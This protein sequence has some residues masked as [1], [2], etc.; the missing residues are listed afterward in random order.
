MKIL[1]VD[2]EPMI[3]AIQSR[4]LKNW[5]YEVDVASDGQTAWEMMSNPAINFVISD[6]M[7]PGISGIDLC[8]KIR[9]AKLDR[10]VYLLLCTAKD[11]R[12]DIVA[13]LDA[14]ADDFLVK[15]IAPSELRVRVRSG[16]RVLNLERKLEDRNLE[17]QAVNEQLEEANLLLEEKNSRLKED[18]DAAAAIQ[19]SLLP[20]PSPSAPGIRAEWLFLPCHYVAGD[21]FNLCSIDDCRT[22]FYILDVSGHGVPAAMLSVQLSVLL[23]PKTGESLLKRW[24]TKTARREARPPQEVI[25]ALNK[26]FQSKEDRYFTMIYGLYDHA[27]SCLR[28]SMAGQPQPLLIKESGAVIPLGEGGY[29]IGIWPQSEYECI[30]VPVGP[31]DRLFLYSDGISECRNEAGEQYGYARII[32]YFQ[33]YALL[34]SL[35]ELLSGLEREIQ[36]WN[37]SDLIF[38]DDISMLLL[39]F[40]AENG[41]NPKEYKR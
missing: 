33:K 10:Y 14:G 19:A 7:M 37:S 25:A 32:Q 30:D 24:N 1:L 41:N 38:E 34:C 15:P 20:P 23:Q 5:G 8:R 3:L 35:K 27:S 2:D 36:R 4:I 12:E 26:Q 31:G 21:I 29:P 6:W 16:E 40:H 39:E 11:R 18:L 17:L 9:D 22:G 13:G 28:L